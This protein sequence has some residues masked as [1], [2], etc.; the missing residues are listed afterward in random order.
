MAFIVPF[1]INSSSYIIRII[2]IHENKSLDSSY[3]IPQL[4]LLLLLE[5]GLTYQKYVAI[6]ISVLSM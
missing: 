3:P 4:H 5:L 2:N 1:I 6:Y